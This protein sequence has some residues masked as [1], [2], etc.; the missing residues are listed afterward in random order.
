MGDSNGALLAVSCESGEIH[1]VLDPAGAV[2]A[3][4]IANTAGQPSSLGVD[5]NGVLYVCDFAHQCILRRGD[6]GELAD[7]VR[8]Y[9]VAICLPPCA[10]FR[11]WHTPNAE[12]MLNRLCQLGR[13]SPS[14]GLPR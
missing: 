4:Q 8:E 12:F 2:V 5:M 1:Q 3:Q 7:F 6:D 10:C 11:T 14:R 13:R 9:E